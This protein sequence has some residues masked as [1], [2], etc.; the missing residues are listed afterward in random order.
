MESRHGSDGCPSRDSVP[1]KLVE[2]AA[3][4]IQV[5]ALDAYYG[6]HCALKD[7]NLEVNKRDY[8]GLIG[9]NGG[10]KTTLLRVL[11]GLVKPARGRV[12]VLGREPGEARGKVGYVPQHTLYSRGFP[13]NVQD[14]VLM[15]RLNRRPG[16]FHRYSREDREAAFSVLERLEI[17]G[18]WDRSMDRLSGGQRQRVL[19]GRALAASPEVLLLDEPTASLDTRSR[20]HIYQLL[21]RLNG[22]VPI[23]LVTHDLGVISSRVKS[24]ACLNVNLHYHGEV[25]L[26]EEV[27]RQLYGCPVELLTRGYT[28]RAPGQ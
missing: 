7:I 3:P 6:S 19:I 21:E 8:L 11:L 16:L 17:A 25:E 15:G 4:V 2:T 23:V 5:E 28:H 22:D 12:R 24:I 18:L 1:A 20:D 14:V 10:G 27:I 26:K 9:P 13:I